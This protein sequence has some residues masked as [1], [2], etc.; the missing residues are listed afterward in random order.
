M[1]AETPACEGVAKVRHAIPGRHATKLPVKHLG[2]P[3]VA[4]CPAHDAVYF[5]VD[6]LGLAAAGRAA[7]TLRS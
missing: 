1:A 7:Y 3:T 6:H 2:E 5:A 4:G